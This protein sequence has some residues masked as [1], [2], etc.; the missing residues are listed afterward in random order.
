[1]FNCKPKFHPNSVRSDVI[2]TYSGA[3]VFE[4][5]T[6]PA[7]NTKLKIVKPTVSY[8]STAVQSNKDNTV[9][10]IFCSVYSQQ[11]A[12]QIILLPTAVYGQL[13]EPLLKKAMTHACIEVSELVASEFYCMHL[14]L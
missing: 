8:C 3:N 6:D 13:Q 12:L 10:V 11:S 1:M 14:D 7:I 5:N 2:Y 4:W 9:I